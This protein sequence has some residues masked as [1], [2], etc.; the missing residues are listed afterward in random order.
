MKWASISRESKSYI[1]RC[2]IWKAGSRFEIC[3]LNWLD[4]R[5]GSPSGVKDSLDIRITSLKLSQRIR[6]HLNKFLIT[7]VFTLIRD[8]KIAILLVLE[9]YCHSG[10]KLR[11]KKF[12]TALKSDSKWLKTASSKSLWISRWIRQICPV[13][14]VVY[15]ELESLSDSERN[16]L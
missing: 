1:G 14:S 11:V 10:A 3:E 7:S 6:H 4:S 15:W 13:P 2:Q 9:Y 16:F 5:A 12:D 8:I